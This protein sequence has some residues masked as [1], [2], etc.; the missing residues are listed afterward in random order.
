MAS[1]TLYQNA[2]EF[3]N[4][5][6]VPQRCG[7]WI[8]AGGRM[9]LDLTLPDYYITISTVINE[10]KYEIQKKVSKSNII[11]IWVKIEHAFSISSPTKD[12]H[13]KILLYN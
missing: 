9:M 5:V 2:K 1:S 8:A 11:T 13:I 12:V 10:I 3:G 7:L 6:V 4:A